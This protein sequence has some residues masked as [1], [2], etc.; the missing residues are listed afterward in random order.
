MKNKIRIQDD[1]YQSVNSKWI[2]KAKI[3]GDQPTIDA[4]DEVQNHIEKILIK[5]FEDLYSGKKNTDI[6]PMNYAVKLYAKVKNKKNRESDGIKPLLPLLEEIKNLKDI[7]ELQLKAVDLFFQGVPMPFD[8]GVT[9]DFKDSSKHVFTIGDPDIILPDTSYYENEEIKNKFLAY[10]TEMMT[11]LLKFTPLS[12]EEQK[13]Y[14]D[15][16]V[17]FD[18]EVRKLVLSSVE[19]ADYVKLY[20]P[21][22]LEYLNEKLMPFNF[23]LF[24]KTIYNGKEIPLR[25]II[26]NPRFIEGFSELFKKENFEKYKHWAYVDTLYHLSSYLSIKMANIARSYSNKIAGI[27]KVPTLSKQAYRFASKLFEE[28]VGLYYGR[29]YFGEKA[30]EDVINI[31]KKI[32]ETYK[33]RMSRNTFLKEETKQ[34]AILK[35]DKIKIKMGYPEKY[36]E[37]Y[38]LLKFEEADSLFETMNKIR[39][40]QIK[41]SLDKIYKDVDPNDWTMPGH[42]VNACYDPSRNDITFPAGILHAPLYDINQKFEE[43]LGGIGATIGHEISHAFDN[44]GAK[45]DENGNLFNWWAKEDFEEFDKLTQNMIKQFDGIKYH[46][47]TVNGTL[48]V[49]ENIADNGGM[50]VTLEILSKQK[51]ADYKSYF[52]NWARIWR[53]KSTES[54]I[55][56]LLTGDVHS[57]AELRANMPPKNFDEWYKTFDIKQGDKMYLSKEERINIW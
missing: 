37:L 46:G 27:K 22:S 42:M 56:L 51:N 5:D 30:K 40:V 31:V 28:P 38:D 45:F 36:D 21:V 3:P 23:E 2:K 33:Y 11:N 20:N 35:L 43:N 16:A 48:V 29:T 19:M 15:D 17:L 52:I 54:Y 7:D 14:I 39:F 8:F 6:V 1:L 26:T 34:K 47:G 57:P 50:A 49:S 4:F 53:K 13:Q 41:Y 32:I 12:K 55:N 25:L 44:N 9:E 24:L 18:D 10:Y